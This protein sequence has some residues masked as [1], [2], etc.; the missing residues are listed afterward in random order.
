MG[1]PK[2]FIEKGDLYDYECRASF[3]NIMK[4]FPTAKG[5]LCYQSKFGPGEWI[6][7]YTIDVCTHIDKY[8]EGRKYC[9][10]V[11][12]SFTSDH[13]ETLVEVEEQYMPVIARQG[14]HPFRV[15]ALNR[16]PEWIDA[17]VQ[18]LSDASPCTNSMLL[19]SSSY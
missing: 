3:G 15:P 18:I 17:I 10:F 2:L 9:V 1:L 5:L 7:P 13:V 4:S 16:Q 19:R 12:I 6:R 8:R 14:L 11:P